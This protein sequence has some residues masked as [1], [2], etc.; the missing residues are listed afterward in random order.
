MLKLIGKNI[1]DVEV[2]IE[3]GLVYVGP[4]GKAVGLVNGVGPKMGKQVHGGVSL[5]ANRSAAAMCQPSRDASMGQGSRRWV[6]V[7]EKSMKDLEQAREKDKELFMETIEQE[8]KLNEEK[9]ETFKKETNDKLAE[10][11][12]QLKEQP[13]TPHFA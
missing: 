1:G 12:A 3:A 4:R 13:P 10:A 6:E 2:R 7:L 5:G 9:F 11:L 8:R